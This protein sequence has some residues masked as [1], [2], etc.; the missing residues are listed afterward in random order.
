MAYIPYGRYSTIVVDNTTPALYQKCIKSL[1]RIAALPSGSALMGDIAKT[2][3]RL[4]INPISG[5]G[6]SSCGPADDHAFLLIAQAKKQNKGTVIKN[7]LT[8]AMGRS[9]MTT[10]GLA[11]ALAGGLAPA[12]Y[13]ATQNVGA[14][15]GTGDAKVYETKIKKLLAGEPQVS[16]NQLHTGLRR[17]LRAWLTPGRGSNADIT[18]N[19]DRPTQCWS[20]GQKK[21]RYPSICLA[22]EMIHAWRYMSGQFMGYHEEYGD[23]YIEEVICTGLPPYNFEKYSENLFRSQWPDE[24]ELRVAY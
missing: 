18:I 14:P 21:L 7:E 6:G 22:H 3:R 13:I 5:G 12:T 10:Q 15:A 17:I 16:D 4:E 2:G 9:K 20:D 8:M 11:A 1:D 23:Q 19:V 24:M